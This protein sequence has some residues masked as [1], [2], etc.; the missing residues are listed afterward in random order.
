MLLQWRSFYTLVYSRARYPVIIPVSLSA[1][2]VRV[3]FTYITISQPKDNWYR[4][5]W[6]NQV[7]QIDGK[8]HLRPSQVVPLA[9]AIFQFDP[10]T[11]YRIRFSPVSWLPSCLVKFSR[12]L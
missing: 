11:S 1:E 7:Y 5:G 9:P 10:S 3:E 12:S 8:P 4:A 6:I 2:W